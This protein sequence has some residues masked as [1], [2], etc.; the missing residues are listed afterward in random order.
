[1]ET[2]IAVLLF[3]AGFALLIKGGDWFVDGSVNIAHRFRIPEILIG[4]TIVAIGTTLPEVMVSSM[5]AFRGQSATAYG[6]AIGS[7]ICNAALISA[8]TIAI[9]PVKVDRS[10]FRTPVIFFFIAAVFYVCVSYF[11]NFTR[12]VG[13]VLLTIFFIYMAVSIRS[14]FKDYSGTGEKE[15]PE[16]APVDESGEEEETKEEN[17]PEGRLWKDI[18]LL[19]LGAAAI[20]VGAFLLVNYGKKIALAMGVPETVVAITFIALGTSLPELVTAIVALV[21]KHGSLS[22]GNIIGA[23]LFNLVLVSGAAVTIKPF[24]ISEATAQ[25]AKTILGRPSSQLVEIPLMLACMLIL[26]IP[27]LLKGKV[28]RWQGVLLLLLYAGFCVYQFAF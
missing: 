26:T 21:K 13:I 6:N 22:L 2:F 15:A 5:S 25:E 11:G 12:W 16:D 24:N 27:P 19:V 3:A 7:I 23:N 10:T 18:L 4:A 20:A 17:L 8:L 9:R 1:M 28:Y 14:A